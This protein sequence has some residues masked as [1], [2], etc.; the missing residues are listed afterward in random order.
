ME[1]QLDAEMIQYL[2]QIVSSGRYMNRKLALKA[3]I[4]KG[5]DAD[6]EE[7]AKQ[8]CDNCEPMSDDELIKLG[9]IFFDDFLE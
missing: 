9:R 1:I 6:K 8:S 5:I 2:N 7:T 4:R 3:I